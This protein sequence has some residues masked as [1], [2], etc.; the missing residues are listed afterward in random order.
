MNSLAENADG[1]KPGSCA[2]LIDRHPTLIRPAAALIRP[3]DDQG[4]AQAIEV[5]LGRLSAPGQVV[6]LRAL[7]VGHPVERST[8][9]VAGLFD[10]EH[11]RD[12]AAA[13]L[14]LTE[15]AAGVYITL[16]SLKPE[17]RERC[18]N[19]VSVAGRGTL[20]ADADVERRRCFFIDADPVRPTFFSATDAE[21]AAAREVILAVRQQLTGL[22]WPA[23]VLADSGNGYHLLYQVDLPADD[24][25][26]VKQ[27]LRSLAARHDSARVKIDTSVFNPSRIFKLYG[28][29]AR[30]GTE[31]AERPHRWTGI[32]DLPERWQPVSDGLLRSLAAGAPSLR[33]SAARSH[34]GWRRIA[35]AAPGTDDQGALEET[36]ARAAAYLAKIPPAVSGQGGHNQTFKAACKLVQGFDLSVEDAFQLLQEWNKRCQP[37]WTDA[38]LLHK[39]EDA[40]KQEVERGY[41]LEDQDDR[42]KDEGVDQASTDPA[43]GSADAGGVGG[44]GGGGHAPPPTGSG[45]LPE[46]DDDP[47][48]LARGFLKARH[49]VPAGLTLRWWRDEWHR[50]R[51][52]AYRA[53]PEGELRAEVWEYVRG[54]FEA[55]ARRP[56]KGKPGQLRRVKKVTINL[57]K[58]VLAALQGRCLVEGTVEQPAWLGDAPFPANEVVA[59]PNGLLHLPALFTGQTVLHPPTPTFFTGVALDY[60]LDLSAPPPAAWLGFLDQ[61]WPNDPESVQALQEW[62]GYTLTADT[63][64]QIILFLVGPPR[65]GKGTIVAVLRRLLGSANVAGPTLSGLQGEFGLQPLLGKS[66]AVIS[67]ARLSGRSDQA[68]IIERLLSISGEDALTVNR[69]GLSMVTTQLP[70]RLMIVTNELPSLRDASGAFLQRLRALVL[71]RTFAGQEDTGLRPRLLRELPGI[72]LWAAEG[73]R[74][75]RGR[76]RF[77]QPASGREALGQLSELASPVSAF[78]EECCVLDERRQIGKK[79]LFQEWQGWCEEHGHQPGNDATFGRNLMAAFPQIQSGR[80][81]TQRRAWLYEGIGMGAGQGGDPHRGV[82]GASGTS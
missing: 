72:L 5:V 15:R 69:K 73:L 79:F 40:D 65:A 43:P 56:R 38:E 17:V 67:D 59:A 30:K 27:V 1:R 48:R 50:W 54:E 35:G 12:L 68:V 57:C 60:D 18:T 66:L 76:G 81:G 52:G 8:R 55:I 4:R 51:V 24:S 39:L 21:K 31:T 45:G 71:K 82:V 62:F 11:F 2:R 19:R 74:R 6:E 36:K 53:Y 9:V 7:N 29:R 58:N 41:L 13:A 77:V 37:P 44:G 64:L 42:G 20:V 10:A 33:T 23:P 70:A 75:L 14:R 49:T 61:I 16:N 47:D 46:A 34:G 78:V 3:P 28:T 32:L 63:S 25:G 22:G 80:E 26:L